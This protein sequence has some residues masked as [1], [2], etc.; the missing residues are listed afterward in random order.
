MS[1]PR[2]PAQPFSCLPSPLAANQSPY[3]APGPL[4]EPAAESS[5][6]RAPSPRP[7]RAG[8]GAAGSSPPRQ[9]PSARPSLRPDTAASRRRDAAAGP[10]SPL[11]PFF[12]ASSHRIQARTPSKNPLRFCPRFPPKAPSRGRLG[13]RGDFQVGPCPCPHTRTHARRPPNDRQGL[14]KGWGVF[15][16]PRA[17]SAGPDEGPPGGAP[18]SPP[19]L[20]SPPGHP[21]RQRGG[22]QPPGGKLRHGG[23]GSPP[24]PSRASA[25]SGV[26]A[27]HPRLQSPP[28]PAPPKRAHRG[29]PRTGVPWGN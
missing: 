4:G 26:P 17:A 14:E 9:V 7:R 21:R 10:V 2:P 5:R 12:P 16:V 25:A 19:A 18:P 11:P 8:R 24:G 1:H 15:T 20:P 29:P 23:R 6:Y 13:P 28:R 27:T 22:G 3:S